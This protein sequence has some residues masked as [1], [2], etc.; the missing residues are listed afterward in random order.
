MASLAGLTSAGRN[1]S[2][3]HVPPSV[4]TGEMEGG[5]HRVFFPSITEDW[6]GFRSCQFLSFAH[7]TIQ[8]KGRDHNARNFD[9]AFLFA[10]MCPHFKGIRHANLE[11]PADTYGQ[12]SFFLSWSLELNARSRRTEDRHGNE[13]SND[14]PFFSMEADTRGLAG[15]SI[16]CQTCSLPHSRASLPDLTHEGSEEKRTFSLLEL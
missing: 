10:Y 13:E 5:F 4:G 8:M 7:S 16:P 1:K 6:T 15:Q 9:P 3:P 2:L 14:H 11:F 12:D